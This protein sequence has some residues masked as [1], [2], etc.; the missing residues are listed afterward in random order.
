MNCGLTSVTFRDKSV[1]DIIA[2]AKEAGLSE[3]EWGADGHV[4]AGDLEL[5]HQVKAACDDALIKLP[6]Y[7]SYYK[8]TAIEDFMPVLDSAK[9]LGTPIIRIWAGRIPPETITQDEFE[10]L[11]GHL[12][13]ACDLASDAKITLALEYHRK[14][15]TQSAQG[16]LRLL[17]AVNRINLKT[18]WQPNP[19]VSFLEHLEEIKAIAPYLV[20]FH[21]F[22]WDQANTR[23]LLSEQ[24]GIQRWRAYIAQARLLGVEPNAL[25]EFV[26]DDSLD[27]FRQD[28]QSLKQLSQKPR[29][30]FIGKPE[31]IQ[32]VYAPSVK[33]Q[34]RILYELDEEIVTLGSWDESFDLLQEAVVLFSTWGMMK[35]DEEALQSALPKLEAV[36]YAAGSVHAFA[37]PFLDQGIRLCCAAEANAIPVA[38]MVSSQILLA[39]KGFFQN[40]LAHSKPEFDLLRSGA[41]DFPGNKNVKVGLLGAGSVGR[42]VMAKLKDTQIE[43]YAYDPYVDEDTLMTLG[44]KKASLEFIFSECQTISNHMP[45]LPSTK[46]I[47]NYDLFKRMGQSTIFINTGR[48]ATLIEA[49]LIQALNEKPNCFALLDVTYPEPPI[50]GSPL[51]TQPN[52]ILTPHIAG[53]IGQEV[54]RLA[55]TMAI[56][57][58]NHL[59][60]LPCVTQVKAASLS[61]KA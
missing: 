58:Q 43:L 50:E 30:L 29:A 34:I 18:Y 38:E 49:D 7:G 32:R 19:E 36:F 41:N 60:M 1:T 10:L 25:L 42:K 35:I 14:S 21:V 8:G 24:D 9:A 48:G 16:A 17:K 56:E 40:A 11:V 46:G 45:D 33:A 28:A 27:A 39:N 12:Q 55:E 59:L 52:L 47:L 2:L 57:A 51:Y 53:S 26:K 23:Y 37:K 5:A 13:E 22:N 3:I 15:M 20:S 61:I 6:S 54:I 44:A 31:E 4:K